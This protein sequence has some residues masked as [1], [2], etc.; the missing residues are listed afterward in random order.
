MLKQMMNAI[1]VNHEDRTQR[2]ENHRQNICRLIDQALQIDP[3][4]DV[5]PQKVRSI[6]VFGAGR[7]DDLEFSFLDSRFDQIVLVDIDAST[8]SEQIA[9]LSPDLQKKIRIE[10]LDF[11][12]LEEVGYYQ[13]L[14]TLS[15]EANVKAIKK[16]IRKIALQLKLPESLNEKKY[17]VVLSTAVYSQLCYVPSLLILAP[18]VSY[19]SKKEIEDLKQEMVYLTHAV[20]ANY[21]KMVVN[22]CGE[23]GRIIAVSDV[24]EISNSTRRQSAGAEKPVVGGEFGI[25]DLK[26]QIKA[27]SIIYD[28][29]IWDF[30]G[31]RK[32]YTHGIA[33]KIR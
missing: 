18:Y 23:N 15:R 25:G 24:A 31:Q 20:I 13:Q 11:S 32:F 5:L 21:N 10:I 29:W 16:W 27:D 8:V 1:N 3:S 19:Y 7:C 2:W 17:D 33:G 14:E 9:K 28:E 22:R 6:I 12:G 30:S 4:V 26:K